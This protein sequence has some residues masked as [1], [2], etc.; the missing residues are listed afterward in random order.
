MV[1]TLLIARIFSHNSLYSKEYNE[2]TTEQQRF[3]PCGGRIVNIALA[4]PHL[5][6]ATSRFLA[7][8]HQALIGG[9]WVDAVSGKTFETFDPGPGG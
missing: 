6:E 2:S 9:K 8:K 4:H 7:G 5:S 1:F 3:R